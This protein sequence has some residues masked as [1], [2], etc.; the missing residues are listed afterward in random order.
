MFVWER[1]DSGLEVVLEVSGISLSSLSFGFDES[2]D[3]NLIGY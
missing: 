1:V 2:M 3:L